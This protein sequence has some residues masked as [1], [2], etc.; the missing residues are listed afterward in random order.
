MV[1]SYQGMKEETKRIIKLLKSKPYIDI[2]R[3]FMIHLNFDNK[4]EYLK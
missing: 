3:E 4:R 1:E 2:Y